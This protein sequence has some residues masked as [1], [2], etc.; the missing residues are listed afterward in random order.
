MGAFWPGTESEAAH[1][2]PKASAAPYLLP[3]TKTENRRTASLL[4]WPDTKDGIVAKG[5]VLTAWH[6]D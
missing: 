3:G 2:L 1:E 6:K 5:Q 4:F